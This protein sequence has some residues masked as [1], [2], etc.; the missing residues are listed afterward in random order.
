MTCVSSTFAG[1]RTM[2]HEQADAII[3]ELRRIATALEIA[4]QNA[5]GHSQ[6]TTL[7][8]AVWEIA[9]NGIN[10]GGEVLERIAEAQEPQ[11]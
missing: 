6:M 4:N 3:V 11:A 10:V 5:V 7:S 1:E 2:D 8:N 9:N